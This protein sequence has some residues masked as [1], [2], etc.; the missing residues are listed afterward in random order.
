MDE[1]LHRHGLVREIARAAR[2]DVHKLLTEGA[3]LYMGLSR[4][5]SMDDWL[6]ATTEVAG[7]ALTAGALG[8]DRAAE[9]KNQAGRRDLYYLYEVDR[10]LAT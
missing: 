9:V 8:Y 2:Q 6:A 1:D 5:T 7:V 4:L 10:R 3:G